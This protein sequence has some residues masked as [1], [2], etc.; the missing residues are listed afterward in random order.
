VESIDPNGPFGAKE[1]GKGAAIGWMY[2][3]GNIVVDAVGERFF[4]RPITAAKVLSVIRK[5][6]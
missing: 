1:A 3:F 4:D 5:K 6:P 2:A